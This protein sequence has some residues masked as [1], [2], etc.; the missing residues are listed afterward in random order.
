[1]KYT[2]IPATLQQ[3]LQM[4]A[5]IVAA[6]FNPATGEVS[7][8]LGATSGGMNFTDVP[9]YVDLGDDID[10]CPKNTKELKRITGREIKVS[11]SFVS[12][13]SCV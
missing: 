2:Q 5:G 1:M 13:S 3:E 11:G 10:N 6:S 12:A 8:L 4:N 7:D 9:E